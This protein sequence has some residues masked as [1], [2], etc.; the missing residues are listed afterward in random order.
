VIKLAIPSLELQKGIF[1]LL[2]GTYPV[3]DF[4]PSVTSYPYVQIGEE[5]LTMDDTKEKN[6]TV[7]NITLH[8]YSKGN[9]SLGAKEVNNFVIDKILNELLVDFFS[10]EMA[11]LVMLT[12]LKESEISEIFHHGVLIF[13]IT[14]K[15]EGNV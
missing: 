9:S 1:S 8:T 12:T 5:V 10:V 6:R 4:V 11:Q 3:Y 7:H 15:L 13:E 14:L 2:N